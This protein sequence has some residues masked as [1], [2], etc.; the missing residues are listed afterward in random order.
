M[1]H[2]AKLTVA[3]GPQQRPARHQ[4]EV[5]SESGSADR[6]V[7]LVEAGSGSSV[8]HRTPGAVTYVQVLQLQQLPQT[9]GRDSVSVAHELLDGRS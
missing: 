7:P 1:D 6:Y 3:L 4:P 5:L 9:G 2:G 8:R